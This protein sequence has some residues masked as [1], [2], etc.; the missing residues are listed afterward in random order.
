MFNKTVLKPV[1]LCV[2]DEKTI[3]DSLEEQ[4]QNKLGKDYDVEVCQS[5]EEALDILDEFENDSRHVAVIVSDQMMPGMKGD[6]FLVQSNEKYLNTPKILLTGQASLEAVRNAINKASLFRYINKPW[7]ENDLM[8]TIKEAVDSYDRHVK[9]EQ[10][11]HLLK[12]LNKASQ[13]ISGEI[14][15]QEL[16]KK[17][18]KN[19]MESSGAEMGCL[20][21]NQEER[22][23]VTNIH[24]I[25][26]D[27]H[28]KLQHKIKDDHSNLTKELLVEIE[29]QRLAPKDY[30]VY[31]PII[32]NANEMGGIYL[33]NKFGRLAFDENNFEILSMLSA[34]AAI[35]LENAFMYVDL[36]EKTCELESDKKI[37]ESI[38][39]DL[40]ERNKEITDS[41]RYAK[42]IQA[43]ILPQLV[44][45]KQNFKDIF[46][47]H[48]AKDIVSGDFYWWIEKD[49]Y[50]WV[51]AVDC[52][53]HGVPGAFMSV[54][55]S[56]SL[57]QTIAKL[58]NPTPGQAL[59]LLHQIIRKS[60]KQ[61]TGLNKDGMDIAL[62]KID[63][64]KRTIEYAGANRP[65]ILIREND[66]H[67]YEPNKNAVG[68]DTFDNS[69]PVFDDKLI[70]YLDGDLI[71]I[72]SDGYADQF[73]GPNHKKISQRRFKESLAQYCKH[74]M[75]IQSEL[76][77]HNFN[78][79][80]GEIEQTDDVLV[81]GIK[82]QGAGY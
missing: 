50:F 76:L 43:T 19:A 13:E 61:E 15:V 26:Q 18:L 52:T 28:K 17:L 81:I 41:I 78:V 62:L 63:K 35:S 65:L 25:F 45:L 30:K 74:P 20:L 60:L 34:Q 1:I 32:K 55:G 33:E 39:I 5:A 42:R 9:L 72:F 27:D 47:I 31:V 54:I 49:N 12:Q 64:N 56:N 37:I 70:E 21:L 66:I 24:S 82:L 46:V 75:Q 2:D 3:L 57:T 77:L 51:A 53:G 59:N 14:D 10:L 44:I 40:E 69:D 71:Y 8:L 22:W 23:T 68:G 36:E 58:G 79:W 67:E 16:L 4:I 38:N 6:Q 7:E 48:Q 73:G 80:K 29:N 11:N